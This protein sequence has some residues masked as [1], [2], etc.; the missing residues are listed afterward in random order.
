MSALFIAALSIL[1]FGLGYLF[2]GSRLQHLFGADPQRK[3]PAHTKFD[4]IDYVPA[5][6]W[7]VLFGHHFAS[8]AGAG[9][10]IGPVIAVA[11]WGWGPALLWIVLGTI[12]IGGVHDYGSLMLSVKHDGFSVGEVAE[13]LISRKAR[14][15]FVAFIWLSLILVVAVF[16]Y[17]C[18]QTLASEPRIVIPSLGL[19][20][21]AILVGYLLYIRK[22]NLVLVTILGLILLAGLLFVGARFPMGFT[23]Q[24]V[25]FWSFILLVYCYAAS[26]AP[27]HIL[28]QPRDYLSSYLLVA[29]IAFGYAGLF[30]SRP[31]LNTPFFVG[32][33]ASLGYL[34]PM[35]FVT[36]A[37][38]AVSGFHCLIASG[39]SSK[40]LANE[41]D[42]KKIGYG[43]MVVEGI[44]AVMALLAVAGGIASW[45]ELSA[46]IKRSD[47]PIGAFG[48]GYDVIARPLLGGYG[49]LIA[50]TILNA[51]ILTTLDTATRIGRYLTEELFGIKNRFLATFIIVILGGWLALSGK[52]NTIWPIFGASNQLVAALALLVISC[53]MLSRKQPTLYT[54]IPC[55]FMFITTVGALIYQFV[56]FS[57]AKDRLLAAVAVV[58]LALAG[59]V[60]FEVI[61]SLR[62]KCQS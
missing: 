4:G 17:L 38:G 28:L 57:K 20:F 3:T 62:K 36:V 21:V 15:V 34:W 19:I 43:G 18:A 51:F 40:Q 47:G 41:R 49:G 29:G 22:L 33:N 24:T 14:T 6:H 55:L 46:I 11:I 12:F 23:K 7:T 8:I 58:L 37:C 2:Y 32:W 53:W 1:I 35:M 25:V 60:V 16:V 9:P 10:I 42:A 52:W 5:K 56:V 13:G 54:L 50:I 44:V 48:A 59:Y 30:L 45:E 61:R 39:T 26:V 31:H 27:V